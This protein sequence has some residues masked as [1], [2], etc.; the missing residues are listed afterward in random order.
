MTMLALFTHPVRL[1][2]LQAMWLLLPLC[3]SVALV[4]KTIR[5]GRPG[6]IPREA[7][8]LILY[9]FGGLMLLGAGLWA[10]QRYWP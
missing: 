7:G 10:V 6:R 3:V 8:V 1:S 2:T 5:A 9:I 4:Y